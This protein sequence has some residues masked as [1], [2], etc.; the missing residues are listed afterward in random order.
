MPTIRVVSY[1]RPLN[2]EDIRGINDLCD[3]LLVK[4]VINLLHYIEVCAVF[5]E[6]QSLFLFFEAEERPTK[7][8]WMS[9]NGA[10][11]SI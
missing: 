3:P 11:A 6:T 9:T 5:L 7:S 1:E 4:D 10:A 8:H 2:T